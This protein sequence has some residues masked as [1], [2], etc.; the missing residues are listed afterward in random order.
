MKHSF[1]AIRVTDFLLRF[2]LLYYSRRTML[3]CFREA[4][5]SRR[6]ALGLCAAS[7]RHFAC[8]VI[9]G[10]SKATATAT[11]GFQY[12]RRCKFGNSSGVL[13]LFWRCRLHRCLDHR[14][15][16]A[17]SRFD[18]ALLWSMR[19]CWMDRCD[20]LIPARTS[21]HRGTVWARRSVARY[22]SFRVAKPGEHCC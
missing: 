13:D 12:G 14:S 22:A 8:A 16:L 11:Q 9:H 18:F 5:I 3:F 6:T 7:W 17:K 21:T 2:V 1:K 4:T 19:R 15:S 10:P 20:W